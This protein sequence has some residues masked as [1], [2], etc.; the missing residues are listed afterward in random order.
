MNATEIET[1]LK[2]CGLVAE[3]IVQVNQLIIENKVDPSKWSLL[4][5]G[6][7]GSALKNSIKTHLPT[8]QQGIVLI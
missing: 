8:Q 7:L 4:T 3:E 6:A 2:S 1:H 5:H